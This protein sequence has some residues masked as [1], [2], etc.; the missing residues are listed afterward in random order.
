MVLKANFRISILR[1]FFFFYK[2]CD[3][4]TFIRLSSACN[5]FLT[6][7]YI[8]HVFFCV[9]YFLAKL[10]FKKKLVKIPKY[11]CLKNN[12]ILMRENLDCGSPV[13]YM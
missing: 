5:L 9:F 3:F 13:T 7:K 10:K 8:A 11:V 12:I 4:V 6:C 2:R 1:F